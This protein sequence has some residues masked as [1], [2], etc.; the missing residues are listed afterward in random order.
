MIQVRWHGRGGQG[1]VTAAEV[2]AVAA[3]KDGKWC[4]AF[5]F[6]GVERRGAPVMA[7]TRISD[8]YIRIRQ[9]VYKPDYV[10]VLDPTLLEVVNVTDGLNPEGM[11]IINTTKKPDEIAL[12]TQAEVR[13]IDATTIALEEIGKP[14]VNTPMLGAFCGAT[15]HVSV[16]SVVE[17]IKER[18]PGEIGEK[19][20]K[21]IMRCYEEVKK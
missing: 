9:Q 20:V 7:F 8:E 4:Q 17:T 5:P 16:E 1:A 15:G 18:Y 2:L 6:F 10:I 14:F 12:D 3:S 11:A 21:A 19:N 13:T